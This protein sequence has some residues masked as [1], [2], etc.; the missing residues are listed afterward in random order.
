MLPSRWI[1]EISRQKHAAEIWFRPQALFTRVDSIKKEKRKEGGSNLFVPRSNY[2]T[3]REKEAGEQMRE[4]LSKKK[5]ARH[6]PQ[7]SFPSTQRTCKGAPHPSDQP[8]LIYN[9]GKGSKSA[10]AKRI[11]PLLQ[12]LVTLHVFTLRFNLLTLR[13]L[14]ELRRTY[15]C[16]LHLSL[17]D[18]NHHLIHFLVQLSVADVLIECIVNRVVHHFL[19]QPSFH[20]LPAHRLH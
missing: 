8:P 17:G 19:N 3:K 4:L 14:R 7:T 1:V 13:H 16:S 11:Q 10:S 20:H 18:L 9:V 6:K 2:P 12:F 15:N 5:R